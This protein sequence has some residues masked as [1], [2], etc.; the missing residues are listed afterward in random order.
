MVN[1]EAHLIS[2]RKLVDVDIMSINA[3]ID[4]TDFIFM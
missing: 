4:T 2:S 1:G 3:V